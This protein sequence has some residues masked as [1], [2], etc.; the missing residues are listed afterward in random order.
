MREIPFNE[1]PERIIQWRLREYNV[2]AKALHAIEAAIVDIEEYG[3]H[4]YDDHGCVGMISNILSFMKEN[5]EEERK[6]E[7]ALDKEKKAIE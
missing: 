4:P 1:I 6:V 3:N 5:M 2:M 7:L